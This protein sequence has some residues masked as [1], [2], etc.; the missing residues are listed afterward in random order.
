MK[1]RPC[2]DTERA[3]P[4]AIDKSHYG[5]LLGLQ[6]DWQQSQ[7]D[8]KNKSNVFPM[9]FSIPL[10]HFIR[11][12]RTN[13][14]SIVPSLES[15]EPS[16]PCYISLSASYLACLRNRESA[17]SC[18]KLSI[19]IWSACSSCVSLCFCIFNAEQRSFKRLLRPAWNMHEQNQQCPLWRCFTDTDYSLNVL[20]CIWRYVQLHRCQPASDVPHVWYSTICNGSQQA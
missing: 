5:F 14:L 11:S 8:T 6:C 12:S 20:V 9:P 10:N 7:A 17:F 19:Y 15:S 16:L 3:H 4:Q 13:P 1:Y 18:L 2:R